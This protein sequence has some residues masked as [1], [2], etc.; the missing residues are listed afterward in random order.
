MAVDEQTRDWQGL[1]VLIPQLHMS[2]SCHTH[3]LEIIATV[4]IGNIM[5]SFDSVVAFSPFKFFYIFFFT[6]LSLLK[7]TLYGH[8][9][10]TVLCEFN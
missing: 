4:S 8:S 9:I 7:Q 1:V 6:L 5:L 10:S 2:V 3:V